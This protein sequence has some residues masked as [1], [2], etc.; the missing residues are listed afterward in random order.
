MKLLALLGA[1]AAL[2][3][4]SPATAQ[5]HSYHHGYTPHVYRVQ[6]RTTYSFGIYLGTRNPYQYYGYTPRG[7][8]SYNYNGPVWREGSFF[9][10]INRF[11]SEGF[12]RDNYNRLVT[13]YNVAYTYRP[14][15][16]Y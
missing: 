9:K 15:R 8:S 13:T 6:P 10:C 3:L 12:L 16:C 7:Y 11:G 14:Y 1:V 4:A 5:H 2:G